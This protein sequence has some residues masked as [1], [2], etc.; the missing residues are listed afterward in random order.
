MH[1]CRSPRTRHN[2]PS[3]KLWKQYSLPNRI[4]CVLGVGTRCDF[5]QF[6][7]N[8]IK[9]HYEKNED[10]LY[11]KRLKCFCTY[12]RDI[13]EYMHERN[14]IREVFDSA[15]DT[16]HTAVH[17]DLRFRYIFGAID[18]Y[19]QYYNWQRRINR[20]PRWEPK[21]IGICNIC[22]GSHLRIMCWVCY[23]DYTKIYIPPSWH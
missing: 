21:V 23:N 12:R 9:S 11:I 17:G 7:S 19:C 18:I 8:E 20:S 2:K 14:E 16:K 1:I 13:R 22:V 6:H 15:R 3:I 4:F 5:Y 10:P